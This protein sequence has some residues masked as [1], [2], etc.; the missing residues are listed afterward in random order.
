MASRPQAYMILLQL[1]PRVRYG[2]NTTVTS[3]KACVSLGMDQGLHN[4]L[5]YSG[6]FDRYFDVKIY[7]VSCSLYTHV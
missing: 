3:N 5:L 2:K 6:A 7:Q 4:Y 1:D